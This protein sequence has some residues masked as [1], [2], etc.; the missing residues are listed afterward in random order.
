MRF[1]THFIFICAH[2]CF[3]CF[4]DL[5]YFLGSFGFYTVFS[6][7]WVV[8]RQLLLVVHLKVNVLLNKCVSVLSVMQ[9]VV[10]NTHR[11]HRHIVS[12]LIEL[13]SHQR[14]CVCVCAC[15]RACV[16][17]CVCVCECACGVRACVRVCVHS[18]WPWHRSVSTTNPSLQSVNTLTFNTSHLTLSQHTPTVC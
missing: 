15:V 17:A 1:I 3:I 5:V 10:L 4:C 9:S 12:R 16:R 13:C 8:A 6:I 2:Y 18:V 11:L 14:V 7:F